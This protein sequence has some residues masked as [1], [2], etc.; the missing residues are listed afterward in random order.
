[1]IKKIDLNCISVSVREMRRRD[2]RH[3]VD[4]D[5][6]PLGIK[7]KEFSEKLRLDHVTNLIAEVDRVVIG[8]LSYATY[9]SN[10]D[11]HAVIVAPELRRKKLGSKLLDIVHGQMSSDGRYRSVCFVIE[12]NLPMH[13]F[14]KSHGYEAA[15]RV[16]RNNATGRDAYHFERFCDGFCSSDPSILGNKR[17]LVVKE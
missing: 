11:I 7:H 8:F 16:I 5:C 2:I 10:F 6:S 3:V 12:D 15:S 9:R 13:L 17:E 4:L 1:M 14:L